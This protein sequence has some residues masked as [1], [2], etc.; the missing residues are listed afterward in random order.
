MAPQRENNNRGGGKRRNTGPLD[1]ELV[2]TSQR[3]GAQVNVKAPTPN[4]LGSVTVTT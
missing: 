4:F 1:S 3:G 2:N